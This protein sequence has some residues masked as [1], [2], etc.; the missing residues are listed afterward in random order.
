MLELSTYTPRTVRTRRPTLIGVGKT[1]IS[2]WAKRAGDLAGVK[3]WT[4]LFRH[5]Y[6]TRLAEDP[7]IDIRSWVELMNHA[8]GSLL[9]RYA[10][11]S[12]VRLRAAVEKL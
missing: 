9:R 4:H 8:D 1:T 5:T 12:D 10:K 3:T 7:D 2:I 11:P 6:A